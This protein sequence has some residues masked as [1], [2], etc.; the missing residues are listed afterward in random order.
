MNALTIREGRESNRSFPL[1]L[2]L[3]INLCPHGGHPKVSFLFEL[4]TYLFLLL[5]AKRQNRRKEQKK[6]RPCRRLLIRYGGEERKLAHFLLLRLTHLLTL[7]TVSLSAT[8]FGSAALHGPTIHNDVKL[9]VSES[10][11][12]HPLLVRRLLLTLV[13]PL[14]I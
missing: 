2:L 1:F 13:N 6:S 4:I 14:Y 11:I 5:H 9:S 3:L 12:F 7:L 10:L 8:R